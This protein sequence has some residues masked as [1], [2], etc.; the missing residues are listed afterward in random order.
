MGWRWRW[1]RGGEHPHSHGSALTRCCQGGPL[2]PACSP[3]CLLS[4]NEAQLLEM[5]SLTPVHAAGRNVRPEGVGEDGVP[6]SPDAPAPHRRVGGDRGFRAQTAQPGSWD[7]PRGERERLGM[8]PDHRHW[9][10]SA[11][12]GSAVDR[13][14]LVEVGGGGELAASPRRPRRPRPGAWRPA[15]PPP[16]ARAAQ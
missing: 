12:A 9:G 7:W 13:D 3:T 14:G 4:L 15:P 2:N 5:V 10:S 1:G 16:P 6:S 8:L 11:R